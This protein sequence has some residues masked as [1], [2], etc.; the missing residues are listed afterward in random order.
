LNFLD[1]IFYSF[2]S[3]VPLIIGALITKFFDVPKKIIAIIMAIGSGALITMV[4]FSLVREAF[5]MSDVVVVSIGFLIGAVIFGFGNH[6]IL[7]RV[8]VKR[9]SSSNNNP[10]K[11]SGISMALGSLMDNVPEGFA[12]GITLIASAGAGISLV[13][14]IAISNFSEALGGSQTMKFYKKNTKFILGVWSIVTVSNIVAATLGFTVFSGM[15][16]R[17]L[18]IILSFA[19][20]AILGMLAETMIPESYKLGGPHISL[21]TAIGFLIAFVLVTQTVYS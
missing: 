15:D 21:A 4:A 1:V 12:I 16:E 17:L 7:K 13:I 20:G 14:A 2:T 11:G 3:S 18:A 9:H 8:I 6:Q 5:H 10:T 19:A